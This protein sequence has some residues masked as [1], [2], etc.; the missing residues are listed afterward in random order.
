M[1]SA[2]PRREAW[3]RALRDVRRSTRAP[4]AFGGPVSGGVLTLQHFSGTTTDLLRG[5]AVE[6]GSGVG[7]Q[8]AATARM[9]A[10]DDYRSSRAIS[11]EYDIPV[12]TEGI[13]STAAVPVLVSG[14]ARGVLYA[15]VRERARFGDRMEDLL[16]G[17]ASRLADD[18]Q[19]WDLIEREASALAARRIADDQGRIAVEQVREAHAEL[20]ALMATIDD[21]VVLERLDGISRLLHSPRFPVGVRLSTREIDVLSLV[22]EGCSYPEVATRL[23]LSPQTVKTYMRD[24]CAKLGVRGRHEAVVVAR[25]QGLL[26]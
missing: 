17:A 26:L 23:G 15:A 2:D 1:A 9:V 19:R 16:L 10:V 3:Q 11:H 18:L 25:R 8:A 6:Q 13:A 4:I 21:P 24:I 20:R 5:L 7:G 12:L 22:A 14:E